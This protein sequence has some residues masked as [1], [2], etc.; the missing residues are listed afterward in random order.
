MHKIDPGKGFD[1]KTAGG[2]PWVPEGFFL[3][4]ICKRVVQGYSRDA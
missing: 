3:L 4:K 2:V 1:N